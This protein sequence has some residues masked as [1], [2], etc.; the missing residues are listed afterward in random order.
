MEVWYNPFKLASTS[1]H[2][3]F[4]KFPLQGIKR[5]PLNIHTEVWY[6]TEKLA[7]CSLGCWYWKVFY[8]LD[9]LRVIFH[10]ICRDRVTKEWDTS[11][12]VVWWVLAGR[13]ISAY[14]VA[15]SEAPPSASGA[16]H[17]HGLIGRKLWNHYIPAEKR[18]KPTQ[19]W[20]I[21][22]IKVSRNCD[23]PSRNE[24]FLTNQF[25]ILDNWAKS[26]P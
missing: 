9:F 2:G 13:Y 1:R 15:H 7:N 5:K 22:I 18:I 21:F 3:C 23:L 26:G 10:S 19:F 17:R 25:S 11:L 14:N 8:C 4:N 16:H 24:I 20:H 12:D 6:K